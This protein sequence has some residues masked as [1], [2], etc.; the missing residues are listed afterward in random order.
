[1]AAERAQDIGADGPD[2]NRSYL[3]PDAA[4][5]DAPVVRACITGSCGRSPVS[6]DSPPRRPD[7]AGWVTHPGT[8]DHQRHHRPQARAD[9][10]G[11]TTCRCC[12]KQ[13][14]PKPPPQ[15]KSHHGPRLRSELVLLRWHRLRNATALFDRNLA[16]TL[17]W[18]PVP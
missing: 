1:M 4:R 10:P 17:R 16:V 12:I 13:V 8:Q 11:R 15:R 18:R 2:S 3:Y 9:A 7:H 5:Y 14:M 6:N